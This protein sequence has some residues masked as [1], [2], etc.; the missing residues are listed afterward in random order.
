M[1]VRD[2]VAPTLKSRGFKRSHGSFRFL[3]DDGVVLVTVSGRGSIGHHDI[4]C[5]VEIGF[6]THDYLGSPRNRAGVTAEKITITDTYDTW[7]TRMRD[8]GL[9]VMDQ[10]DRWCFN[11]GDGA[12]AK[13]LTTVLEMAADDAL[14]RLHMWPEI[15][16]DSLSQPPAFRAP[17]EWETRSKWHT[18]EAGVL[19]L[20][21]AAGSDVLKRRGFVG[22]VEFDFDLIHD[23]AGAMISVGPES[24]GVMAGQQSFAQ[25]AEGIGLHSLSGH[26]AVPLSP[27]PDR[28]RLRHADD[29]AALVIDAGARH[30]GAQLLLGEFPMPTWTFV[31][32][33]RMAQIVV[34]GGDDNCLQTLTW[35]SR[36]RL[37]KEGKVWWATVRLEPT[38]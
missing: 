31:N 35:R 17:V 13:L 18:D 10:N 22:T 16:Q 11:Q 5:Y 24:L 15:P 30:P 37:A 32:E 27:F 34:I 33:H 20:H 23:E 19:D 12:M 28:L 4:D 7:W 9:T 38:E 26:A 1:L 6:A 8:P 36:H 29:E 21:Y 2:C 25:W 14:T 3:G